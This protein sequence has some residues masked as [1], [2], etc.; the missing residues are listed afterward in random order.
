[1]RITVGVLLSILT[2]AIAQNNA[3][4]LSEDDRLNKFVELL[5]RAGIAAS[6]GE[7]IFAPTTEAF[8]TFREE[9]VGLWNKYVKQP[10][11]FLH[12]RELMSWH[13]VTQGR[14]TVDEIFDGNRVFLENAKGN[15]TV[16]QRFKKLDN[17]PKSSIIEGNITTSDGIIH[18][19]DQV[20]V[21]PYLG[22]NMIE[23]M[24]DDQ[25]AKFAFTTMANLALHVGLDEKINAM[26]ENGLTFLVPPNRR[27]NRAQID[28][29]S[30]LEPEMFNYTRDFVL[31]HMIKNNYYEAGVFAF[32]KE[33]EQEQ[34][35]VTSELGTSLWI[36]TT[37]D[38]LRFQ[39]TDVLL[40]DQA[41]KNG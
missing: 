17:L 1:M 40:Y 4:T 16:D 37:E 33:N 3:A 22:M 30:L 2:G 6:A 14:F 23:Q 18:V 19:T 11:F 5:D 39:S 7:T 28:V 9:D 24:L 10:E 31:C 35:L 20:M 12:L 8:Q 29:P 15:I 13:L 41:T 32:N 21:P 27:F 26:Y 36:T 38:R 25:S 34:F